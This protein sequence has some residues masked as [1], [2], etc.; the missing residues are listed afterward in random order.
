MLSIIKLRLMNLKN[1][2]FIIVIM[3]F[4][5]LFLTFVMG[6]AFNGDFRSNIVLVDQDNSE[7]SK[8]LVDEI[9]KN[10]SF[11]FEKSN[12]ENAFNK[13]DSEKALTAL[14]IKEGFV[15]NIEEQISPSISF[16]KVKDDMEIYT[17]QNIVYSITNNMI[18]N[19]KS[20]DNTVNYISSLNNDVDKEKLFN[21]TYKKL[22]ESMELRKPVKTKLSY[23]NSTGNYDN[24]KHA[25]IGYA[26]FFS[27]YTMV[28]SIGN[29]LNDRKYK[30]W[31][32]ILISP[33][34]N[35]SFLSGSL[36]VSYLVGFLQLGVLIL[37]GK[38]LFNVDWGNSILGII[39][40]ASSFV[41][42]VTT[43]G[44]FL[45]GIVKTHG[46]L[47]AITPIVL[48]ST[49]MLGGCMWP[50]EMVNNK[51]LL[52]LSNITPQKWAV[53]G[54]EKI[55]MY[56][57]GLEAAIKPTIVLLGMGIIFLGVGIRLVKFEQN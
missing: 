21:K 50:L 52:L 6:A 55:A 45:S 14:V 56:G 44:L 2:Y 39:L 3:T 10:N 16:I 4:M 5:A 30:T 46:Q 35:S 47:S 15:K 11:K 38:Y 31:D 8:I 1:E 43:L 42:A 22:S 28:F 12:Y 36:I 37:S 53:S 34:S 27:M 20:A 19:I 25:V 49:A 29:I 40:I 17:I 54:M 23:I 24:L 51:S 13:V 18:G 48:T 41:F 32:R 33:V 7:Y 57:G 9:T 26:L